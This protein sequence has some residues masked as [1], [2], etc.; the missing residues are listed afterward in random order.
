MQKGFFVILL[1]VWAACSVDP[2]TDLPVKGNLRM[3]MFTEGSGSLLT[4][5]H[6]LS[7]YAFRRNTAGQYV[8][9]KE[10][11]VLGSKELAGLA[12]AETGSSYTSAKILHVSLPA[13]RY[14]LY[15]VGNA[16]VQTE[17]EPE[18]GVTLPGDFYMTYPKEGLYESYFRGETELEAGGVN[19]SADV[20]LKRAVGRLFLK[21]SDIPSQIDSVSISLQGVADKIYIDGS[22]SGTT[23][24]DCVYLVKKE[25]VYSTYTM[26]FDQFS[27]PSLYESSELKLTFTAMSGVKKNK[28]IP[29]RLLPDKYLYLTS[30]ISN[31]E[32]GLLNFDLNVAFIFVWDWRDIT[33]PG[34]VLEPYR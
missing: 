11:A 30:R 31:S 10:I 9:Y 24:V 17:R 23:A 21:I 18:A 13:G 26:M 5:V 34:F 25:D 27:F 14:R 33:G 16:P 8:F 2:E 22:L 6:S 15:F 1:L 32:E 20:V 3:N 4:Y 12:E 19:V 28:I 29:V 7:V